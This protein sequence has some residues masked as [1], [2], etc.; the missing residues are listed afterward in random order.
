MRTICCFLTWGC[1]LCLAPAVAAQDYQ[2]GVSRA[3]ITPDGPIWMSGYG[4]RNK[5]SEGVDQQLSVKALAIQ[6]G[7]GP[8]LLLITADIIGFPGSVSDEIAGR[9]RKELNIPRENLMLVASHTHTGPVLA[10]NLLGMFDLKDKDL[11]AVKAHTQKLQE[12]CFAVAAEAV[13]ELRPAQLSFARGKATFAINRRVFRPGGVGFGANPTGVVDHEVP[14]LRIDNPD[15]TV[16]AILFGYACHGTTLGGDHYRIGGD[17][18]GYAQEFLERAHPGAT[19]LFVTG[20]GADANPEPRGKLDFAR[21]HGLELAGA[22]TQA[23]K[24]PRTRISGPL[25]AAFD[26]AE[27]PFALPPSREEFEK[28]LN[29][30]DR[31]RV[32]HARRQLE[33]LDRDGKLPQSHPCP[34]QAWQLGNDLTWIALGGEVV[35]DYAFRL[36]R[37]IKTPNLWLTGYANDV[38]AYVPSVR[39]LIE[40]GYEADYNLIYYGL[41]TRFSNDVEEVLVKK[42]QEVV[43]RVQGD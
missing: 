9:I 27:L 32:R 25:K 4:N 37:D 39:I 33:I 28:R 8:P 1:L 35:V 36:K 40:G 15:G 17:W 43:K 12:K 34:V 38:F 11:E 13:K 6:E 29:E 10:G 23:L 31:F 24:G 18:M 26:R 19:A 41:P 7:K 5:P 30:K 2:V 3:D 16:R 42:V 21:Q 22:V 20:F 14:V